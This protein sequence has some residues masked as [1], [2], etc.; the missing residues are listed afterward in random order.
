[1]NELNGIPEKDFDKL[2]EYIGRENALEYIKRENYNYRAVVT[3][4]IMLRMRAY[5][6]RN[7]IIFWTL[8][9]SS[10]LFLG[11]YIFSTIHY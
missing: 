8:L 5:A 7:P 9:I 10:V 3:K 4:L 6:K 1:M 2:S 11:Y